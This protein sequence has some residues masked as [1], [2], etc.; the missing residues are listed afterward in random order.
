M[1]AFVDWAAAKLDY[2][3]NHLSYQQ[4]ADKYGISKRTVL[5]YA[6]ANDWQDSKKNRAEKLVA[7]CH[8][9]IAEQYSQNTEEILQLFYKDFYR[10]QEKIEQTLSVDDAFAPKD[11][12]ALTGV[13]MDL[14][15]AMGLD[16]VTKVTDGDKSGVTIEFVN[17]VWDGEQ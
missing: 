6:K 3:V 1:S 15:T 10:I 13:L 9:K 4:I 11:L 17:N 7:E 8:Q 5:R 16:D 14:K 12:K 2:T